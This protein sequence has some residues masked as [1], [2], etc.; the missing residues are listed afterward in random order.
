MVR[1]SIRIREGASRVD[2]SVQAQS[3]RRASG[4]AAARYPGADVQVSFPIDDET[5]FVQKPL[6]ARAEL[7][8]AE[9]PERVAA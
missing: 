6:D 5:F 9:Q 8:T 1:V 7:L 3:I 4:I 2:V